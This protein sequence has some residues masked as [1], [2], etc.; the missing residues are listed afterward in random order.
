MTAQPIHPHEPERVPRNAEG[1]AAA[2]DGAR[3]MEFYRELLAA[4]PEEAEGVLRHWWCEA[5][6]DTDPAGDRLTVA[7][8][9]GT[10][11]TTAVG[12]L[13]ERRRAAGLPVE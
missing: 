3:R 8:L 1:I 6:L 9:D 12:E 5:M 13:I 11:P 10:L 7:A 4:A 2:L